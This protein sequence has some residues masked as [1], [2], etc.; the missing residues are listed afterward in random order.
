VR[1]LLRPVVD[2][3]ED[4]GDRQQERRLEGAE[5]AEQRL[6]VGGVREAD[7]RFDAGELDQPGEDVRPSAGRW[8][9]TCR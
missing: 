7:A 1:L 6:D 9:P 3:L 8:C 2:L 5:V 4:A